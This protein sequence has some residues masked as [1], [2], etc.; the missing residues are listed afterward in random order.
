M[1]A[2]IFGGI[3][4]GLADIGKIGLGLIQNHQAN[5][6]NPV[7]NPYEESPY[8]K[9]KLGIAEQLFGG[10]MFGAPELER[11]LL[12]S[13]SNYL[14]NVNRNATDSGQALAL[15]AGA[16]G[17]TNQ[18]FQNLQIQEAQNKYNLLNNLN[19][20]YQGMITEGDKVYQ[21]MLNK[22]QL[23]VAEKTALRGAAF[24]NIFGGISDI[25][26]GLIQGGTAGWFD[27]KPKSQIAPSV[28][29]GGGGG[30]DGEFG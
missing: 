9:E 16:Q 6:I 23:D 28:N 1:G 2:G 15:A 12:N 7:Y 4:G 11:N 29:S 14:A 27:K 24:N 20:G 3:L 19:Q 8:A 10:R 26:G 21:D 25:G 18:G 22:Y 5:K 13:Q 17:M 30:F